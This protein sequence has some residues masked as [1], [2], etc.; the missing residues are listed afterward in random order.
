MKKSSLVV[1][2]R[3]FFL[4]QFLSYTCRAF[5]TDIPPETVCEYTA[6]MYSLFLTSLQ[7]GHAPARRPNTWTLLRKMGCLT[8]YIKSEQGC[9]NSEHW[10]AVANFFKIKPNIC[11]SSVQ[12][13]FFVTH[14][15]P[16]ILKW[17]FNFWKTC[18]SLDKVIISTPKIKA[19]EFYG[20]VDISRLRGHTNKR[21]F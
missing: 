18:A 21:K 15:T 2:C 4:S 17:S 1:R 20:F 3:S 12:S 7:L 14:T 13:I 6:I 8:F 5:N 9:T 10:L 16:R 19:K 11:G